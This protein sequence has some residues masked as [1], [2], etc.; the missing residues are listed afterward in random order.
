L[1]RTD[2]CTQGVSMLDGDETEDE[3][4]SSEVDIRT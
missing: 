4:S 3:E 1:A 2:E